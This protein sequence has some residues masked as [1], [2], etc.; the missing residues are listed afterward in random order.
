LVD[1]THRFDPQ[2]QGLVFIL[3]RDVLYLITFQISPH[4][5]L[6]LIDHYLEVLQS[7][8]L[9][10]LCSNDHVPVNFIYLGHD[11]SL[12]LHELFVGAFHEL[13]ETCLLTHNHQH[14]A[15]VLIELF[16]GNEFFHHIFMRIP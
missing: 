12:I 4:I 9:E 14:F 10:M 7:H 5:I 13:Q 15:L 8:H 1:F 6:E 3:K 2:G 11:R 16:N